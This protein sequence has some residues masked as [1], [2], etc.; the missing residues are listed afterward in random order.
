MFEVRSASAQ[1]PESPPDHGILHDGFSGPPSRVR[2][3]AI[4]E[5]M[6][7]FAIRRPSHPGGISLGQIREQVTIKFRRALYQSGVWVRI[8]QAGGF[9]RDISAGFFHR[10]PSRLHRLVPWLKRE[11]RVLCGTHVSLV[12][13]IQHIILHNMTHYDL[14]SQA[15][16]DI[17]QPHLLYYTN[18]FLHEFINF[19]RS[20]FNI[21]AYD[22]R[23]NYD[24]PFLLHEEGY[25]F[26]SSLTTSEEEEDSQDDDDGESIATNDE[27]SW[28][29]EIPGSTCSS[30]EQAVDDLVSTLGSSDGEFVRRDNVQR[31]FQMQTHFDE[32]NNRSPSDNC[33]L[34]SL[35]ERKANTFDSFSNTAE[36]KHDGEKEEEKMQPI[37]DPDSSNSHGAGCLTVSS[38]G[39]FDNQ[40][41]DTLPLPQQIQPERE[42]VHITEHVQSEAEE[43]D[44]SKQIEAKT[45]EPVIFELIRSKAEETVKRAQL[46]SPGEE[47]VNSGE[48]PSSTDNLPSSSTKKRDSRCFPCIRRS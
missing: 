45:E 11:L 12:N 33:I 40:R 8:V 37:R 3:R 9:Y 21:K 28:D 17:L 43:I 16:A 18:H 10:N 7:Q 5:L 15:F 38:D 36:T 26:Y 14:E 44:N 47:I 27:D 31:L 1:R 48:S 23:A 22:W 24:I 35:A 13:D 6:R 2:E 42:V 30:L 4:D 41:N 46:L 39:Q 29:D 20:P 19:A 25:Q 32:A 34:Y